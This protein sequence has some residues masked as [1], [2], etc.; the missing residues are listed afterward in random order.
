MRSTFLGSTFKI[1]LLS[2]VLGIGLASA[3]C[4]KESK[5][6]A[7]DDSA[8][9]TTEK[10]EQP[11]AAK[12]PAAEKKAIPPTPEAT[13]APSSSPLDPSIFEQTIASLDGKP[14]KLA[15][16]KGKA[17]LL[18]NVASECGLT[19][20]YETLE[21]LQKTYGCKGFTVLGVQCNQI[22]GQE[23]GTHKEISTFCTKNYG[24]TFPMT[25]KVEVNG[26]G[27]HPI[28]D[29]LT[30]TPDQKG[31]DGDVQWN[32]EKFLISSDGKTVSRF[33]PKTV[34]ND[35]VILAAIKAGLP[36]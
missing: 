13:A 7:A 8:A 23:P 33:R 14:S 31:K 34:P 5:D 6:S 20:Q 30:K 1:S 29:V 21:E 27:R 36:K 9:K 12:K 17:I 10:P 26:E 15:D 32:F 35:P 24:V 4:A 3:S 18:V 28:Y 19:P 25:E 11:I 16:H 2:I 22:G